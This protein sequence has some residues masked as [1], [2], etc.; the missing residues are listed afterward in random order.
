MTGM[1]FRSAAR[2]PFIVGAALLKEDVD[3]VVGA[4]LLNEDVED[5]GAVRAAEE[6]VGAAS[7]VALAL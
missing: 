2:L 1:S 3:D 7:V 5:E 4:A 6:A